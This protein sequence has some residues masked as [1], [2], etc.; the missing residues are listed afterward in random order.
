MTDSDLKPGMFVR[1][2]TAQT[3]GPFHR[4]KKIKPNS[5]LLLLS[6]H[7][8]THDDKDCI[9]PAVYARNKSIKYTF[10]YGDKICVLYSTAGLDSTPVPDLFKCQQLINT[11]IIQF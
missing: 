3:F 6:S 5:L 1:T 10:L 7:L 8:V 11:L 9:E 2:S 4:L